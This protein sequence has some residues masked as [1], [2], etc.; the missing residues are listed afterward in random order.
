MALKTVVGASLALALVGFAHAGEWSFGF[1]SHLSYDEFDG[2]ERTLEMIKATGADS[3]RTD[4]NFVGMPLG[5]DGLPDFSRHE[6]IVNDAAAKGVDVLA[7]L[8]GLPGKKDVLSDLELWRTCVTACV[9]HFKGRIRHWEVWNEPNLPHQGSVADPV[10]YAKVLKI[11]SESIRA[12]DPSARVVFAGL[13]GV[14]VE[15]MEKV[16]GEGTKDL[17][18]VM[19]IH[20]YSQPHPPEETYARQ[21]KAL[22]KVMAAN[23]DAGK[24][25]WVTE[26]GWPT[27]KPGVSEPYVLLSGLKMLRPDRKAWRIVCVDVK[28]GAAASVAQS[29]SEVVPEGWSVRSCQADK[30]GKIL[31]LGLVDAVAYPFSEDYPVETVDAVVDFVTRGGTLIEI[32]GYPLYYPFRDGA[33]A[34]VDT[35]NDRR[36]LRIGADVS[37]RNPNLPDNNPTFPTPA[38]LQAGYKGDPAGMRTGVYLD[39]RYL[40]DGDT[41]E[42]ITTGK[43]KDGSAVVGACVYRFNSDMKGG[44]VACGRLGRGGTATPEAN[45]AQYMVRA[46]EYLRTNGVA[47]AF[48]YEFRSPEKDPYY[49]EDNF[50]CVHR[51]FAPKPAYNALL[52]Y[53]RRP[54]N[55]ASGAA[56][57]RIDFSQETGPVKPVNAVGQPPMTGAPKSFSRLHYIKEAH[58][59]FSRLHDVHGA[60]GGMVY[61]DIPNLFRDFDADETKPENYDFAFTDRLISALTENGVEP[62]FRLGVTIENYPDVKRYRISPPK[63]PA[64]W[65]RICEHVIR[66]YTE[67]WADG[68]RHS[69]R[70]WEIWNEPDFHPDREKNMMWYGDFSEFCTLYATAAR[71]LKACFPH[72]K[73]G[74]FGS[75][76]FYVASEGNPNEQQ[77]HHDRC[78]REFFAMVRDGKVPFDFFSFHSYSGT[79]AIVKQVAYAQKLLES[80]GLGNVETWLDEWLPAPEHEELGTARQAAKIGATLIALQD[81]S[82]HGACI[83]DARCGVGR[84]SPLFNPLTLGPHKAYY[85]MKAFGELAARGTAVKVEADGRDGLWCAAAKGKG[86]AAAMLVNDTDSPMPITCDFGGRRVAGCR[87]TDGERTDAVVD[88]PSALPPYAV[89]SLT[90]E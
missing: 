6:A 81:S 38:A 41:M 86:G 42:P 60:Y 48:I 8:H 39:G 25:V 23:G 13:A 50:G 18:D 84:F 74:G 64:K 53:G 29:L 12:E 20:I 58:I 19:N 89:V 46:L 36:R 69:I 24:P 79:R 7:V 61:V 56:R 66:H 72:L 47:R 70:Y 37:W 35:E 55:G 65:A 11:A 49:S 28:P 75:C 34:Q 54:R 5:K 88:V 10:N 21:L 63:D 32:G 62:F 57:V 77:R 14:P 16:Y 27:Q 1:C 73:I 78:A 4:F 33:K 80:Y 68:F 15:Y 44:I 52:D 59:P 17:F 9:R 3:V 43:A 45:Q 30:L 71:H 90:F 82:L 67:G 51:D 22:R 40:K 83:Y 85:A 76:G 26:L 87:L 2:R 31:E